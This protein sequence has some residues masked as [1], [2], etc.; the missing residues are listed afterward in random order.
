MMEG[1]GR[2]KSRSARKR[3]RKRLRLV[4]LGLAAILA[5]AL[6]SAA[7]YGVYLV[8]RDFRVSQMASESRE[9]LAESK[10]REALIR[11][12]SALTLAPESAEAWRS[13]AAVMETIGNPLALGCYEKLDTLGESTEEDRR[14]Y[15]RAAVRLGQTSAA[16]RQAELLKQAGDAG[17]LEFVA[18]DAAMRQGNRGTAEQALRKVPASSAASRESRLLLGQMLVM[19]EE[20]DARSEALGIFRELSAGDDRLAASALATGLTGNLVPAPERADW[21]AKLESHPAG[22]EKTFLVV[23]SARLA[24]DPS[25]RPQILEAVVT[26][27]ASRGVELRTPAV[28]WLNGLQEYDLA[29]RLLSSNEARG[30]SDAFVAW[31]D[32]LAG[33]GDWKRVES[34]LA[35]GRIPLQGVALEMFRARA[36][37][38]NGIE[39]ASRQGYQ[40][41]INM[42]LREPAKMG[43]VMT[44]L[45]NDGQM[46]LLRETLDEALSEPAT[47]GP[48]RDALIALEKRS[49]D[50]GKMRALIARLRKSLPEDKDLRSASI[51]YDLVLGNRALGAEAFR[52][53]S[54]EPDNF[55]RRAVHALAVLQQ[56][57]PDK[58]VRVFDGLSV[59]SDLI[60]PEQ[61]AIVVS[62]LAAQGRM[63]Q[64]QAMAATLIE[65]EL[66]R[67]EVAMVGNYLRP[68]S[69]PG[70]T[71]A[72]EETPA[73]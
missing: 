50:A 31:L 51:Y 36:S 45:E 7:V 20:P 35:G 47:A 53:R 25:S 26:H 64:A 63:D 67:E 9:H 18:A 11:A 1:S 61:K 70:E 68:V 44:F 13:M 37:R 17:F 38:M 40:R 46:D 4:Y 27:F 6:L 59:R 16:Q 66:T 55:A 62:V 23:Q 57:F 19:R 14:N 3:G 30:S 54:E 12:Q 71:P 10:I 15:V 5:A 73:P 2:S 21:A 60:T 65:S 69:G 8:I 52:M 33:K 56:G 34:S 72:Q 48:A 22:D 43:S 39:G 42:A 24:N 29:L 28:V 32:T 41:A 58:A 49:R